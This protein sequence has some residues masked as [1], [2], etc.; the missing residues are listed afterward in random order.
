MRLGALPMW[1]VLALEA[2]RW[3]LKPYTVVAVLRY[4]GGRSVPAGCEPG[5]CPSCPLV[6]PANLACHA[7]LTCPVVERKAFPGGWRVGPTSPC[8]ATGVWPVAGY[9]C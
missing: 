1:A 5:D 4:R 6:P 3:L 9:G 8:C 7:Y 2:Y